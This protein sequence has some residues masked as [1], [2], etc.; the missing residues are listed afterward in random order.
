VRVARR[1]TNRG[2]QG[3]ARIAGRKA[4]GWCKALGST[5]I[6]GREG[7]SVSPLEGSPSRMRRRGARRDVKCERDVGRRGRDAARDARESWF[8]GERVAFRRIVDEGSKGEKDVRTCPPTFHSCHSLAGGQ[9]KRCKID[10]RKYPS[11]FHSWVPSSHQG[12][13]KRRFES[14]KTL[15]KIGSCSSLNE[16]ECEFAGAGTEDESF[17]PIILAGVAAI[18]RRAPAF[19]RGPIPGP[20][21]RENAVEV[22]YAWV[23]G[24]D[25]S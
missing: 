20:N 9:G 22:D 25:V 17:P 11:T 21:A 12:S 5:S 16:E 18:R 7:K 3:T 4:R 2:T 10:E 8:P 23:R 19:R 14:R 13:R 15:R 1:S 24:R 6:A